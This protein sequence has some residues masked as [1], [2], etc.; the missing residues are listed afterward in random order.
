MGQCEEEAGGGETVPAGRCLLRIVKGG[1]EI[2]QVADPFL[3][4]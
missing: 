2:P 3:P 1:G 4:P